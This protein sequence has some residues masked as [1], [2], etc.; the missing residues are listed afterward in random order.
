LSA[1]Y[2]LIGLD[3][4]IDP[5]NESLN[6]M[7]ASS[8]RLWS[9]KVLRELAK[10]NDLERDTFIILAGRRYREFL[11]AGISHHQVPLGQMR[12]GEQIRYLKGMLDE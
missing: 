1:K 10:E 7:T 5:Y 12:I 8:R 9:E 3:R 6:D 2:G 11:S 4:E